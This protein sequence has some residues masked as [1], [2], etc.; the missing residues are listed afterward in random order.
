M[1]ENQNPAQGGNQGNRTG[2]QGETSKRPMEEKDQ[3]GAPE[4]GAPSTGGGN[5]G[6]NR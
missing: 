2:N 4:K 5:R 3:K 6:G 1:A